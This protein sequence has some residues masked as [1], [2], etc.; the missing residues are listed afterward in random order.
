MKARHTKRYSKRATKKRKACELEGLLNRL[1]SFP[2][3]YSCLFPVLEKSAFNKWDAVLPA[4]L[5][6]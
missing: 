6:S 3:S 4:S 1:I 2:F 5:F